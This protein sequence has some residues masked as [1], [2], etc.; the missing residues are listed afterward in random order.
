MMKA[1]KQLCSIKHY[2]YENICI[3]TNW[4]KIL[5]SNS[6]EI[7]Q[8]RNDESES[9]ATKL[10]TKN[11]IETLVHG[12]IE[13]CRTHDLQDIIFEVALV[14]GQNPLTILKDKLVE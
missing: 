9:E 3:N 4:H 5:E 8:T 11:P 6:Q 7:M 12:F 2:K 14:E 10:E 1:L 13:S